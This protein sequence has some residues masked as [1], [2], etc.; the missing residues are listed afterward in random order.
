M[1]LYKKLPCVCGHYF[2]SHIT[3]CRACFCEAYDAAGHNP[4]LENIICPHCK[5]VRLELLDNNYI[6][7]ICQLILSEAQV[8]EII[9]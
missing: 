6:C 9:G 3:A 5:L 7:P 4:E 2:S 8:L 1:T